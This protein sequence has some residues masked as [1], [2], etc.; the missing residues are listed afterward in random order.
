MRD[1]DLVA[2]SPTH[3]IGECRCALKSIVCIAVIVHRIELAAYKV[4]VAIPPHPAE[5][6][7]GP[8]LPKA[9]EHL[10]KPRS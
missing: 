8:R 10:G 3:K 5:S 2:R 9:F 4:V 6:R 1:D 7:V